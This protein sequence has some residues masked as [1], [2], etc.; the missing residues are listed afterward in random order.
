MKDAIEVQL[1][2]TNIYKSKE[3]WQ[4]YRARGA[5][6]GQSLHAYFLL[7]GNVDRPIIYT[8]ERMRDGKS[9]ATRMVKASQRGKT[10]FVCNC[11]FSTLEEG[12][13]L[14]HQV[15]MPTVANPESLPS[16]LDIFQKILRSTKSESKQFL[17][18]AEKNIN[19]NSLID[20]RAVNQY[21]NEEIITG[22][23]KTDAHGRRW[24]KTR[25]ALND[26]MKLHAC[27]IAYASDSGLINVA[28]TANGLSY[29]SES[30][31]M[32]ASLDHTMW[33]H[34]PARADDWLLYD[35]HSPRTN[36]GRGVA[37]GKIYSSDGT[38]VV[39]TAQEG[40]VRLTEAEQK[41]RRKQLEFENG[42]L[43]NCR[44]QL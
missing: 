30:M 20:Y 6:G 19:D 40:I 27:I 43:G 29:N 24:F 11:S 42:F 18:R 12:I 7:A 39:T 8:V 41:K 26:D 38:L 25:G 17:L 31:G 23:V 21:S 16:D 44:C 3:L 9:Y 5:F 15:T 4:P 14:S 37:F 10:I 35:I 13:T 28:A 34:A 22:N 36:H 32:M 33:F 1:I 2:D